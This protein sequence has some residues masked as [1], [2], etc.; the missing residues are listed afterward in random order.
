M[1]LKLILSTTFLLLISTSLYADTILKNRL[2]CTEAL[3]HL[4]RKGSGTSFKFNENVKNM[5]MKE[6]TKAVV[7]VDVQKNLVTI[8]GT[9]D[10]LRGVY[11][12]TND[13]TFWHQLPKL[14]KKGEFLPLNFKIEEKGIS[15]TPLYLTYYDGVESNGNE[16]SN[17]SINLS[18]IKPA[19]EE[20]NNFKTMPLKA[21]QDQTSKENFNQNFKNIL[22]TM[23]LVFERETQKVKPNTKKEITEK[24]KNALDN[25]ALNFKQSNDQ[26][27]LELIKSASTLF[28]SA[29]D[30]S[31]A[32]NINSTSK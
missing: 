1:F 14:Q 8:P 23:P 4:A 28:N 26:E 32:E 30:K 16:Y 6:F 25:C 31:K 15:K 3:S 9:R 20:I 5:N 10:G 24:Y 19:K 21:L 13:G 27:Y 11:L 7:G 2:D 22:N 18:T 17:K 29:D 12:Y